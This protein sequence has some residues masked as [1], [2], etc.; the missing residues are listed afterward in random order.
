M[1]LIGK[2][3][4]RLE[5]IPNIYRI[6][7]LDRFYRILKDKELIFVKP[8]KWEDPLENLIFNAKVLKNGIEYFHPAKDKIFGQCW[9]YE[10]DSYGI[11]KIYTT[12]ENDDGL[13]GRHMG[14]RITTN[15]DKLNSIQQKNNC[16]FYF[17]IVDYLWK[18]DLEKLPKD[19][20]IIES[21][22]KPEINE[23]LISTLLKKRKSYSFEN[24]V[25]LLAIPNN[26][27]ID[28]GKDF[29]CHVKID[30][31]DFITSLRFDPGMKYTEFKINKDR[32]VEEF[33][34]KPTQITQSTYF[35]K[36][37]FVIKI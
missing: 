21:L 36:N 3:N 35:R 24:E 6:E 28:R 15:L 26:S 25:R 18:K 30:P 37:K 23:G 27:M 4:K 19:N 8:K 32:L 17:G 7:L 16:D 2:L 11:W 5:E 9:S 14:V 33:G 34:F 29:L 22:R 20:K 1:K 13:G 10:G 12:K 31:K